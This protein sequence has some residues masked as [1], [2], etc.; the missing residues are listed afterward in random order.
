MSLVKRT[1]RLPFLF[2]DFLTTDWLGG[3][4]ETNKIN[5][6]I[7]AVNIEETDE[8]FVLELAAPGLSKDKFD[9][10]LDNDVLVISS[11]TSSVNE[12]KEN[13]KYTRKEFSYD[14]FKRTFAVPE[15]VNGNDI[16]ASYENGILT[17]N[18]PKKEEA[19]IQ[20]KRLIDIV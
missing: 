14:S 3:I 2:D 18:L 19:K 20:P 6:N 17:I 5:T 8:G 10:E 13:R 9:L 7:P 15:T 4:T 11:E 12:D 16:S 1:N